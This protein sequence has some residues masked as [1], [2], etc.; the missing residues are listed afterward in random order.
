MGKVGDAGHVH[1]GDENFEI[2]WKDE[3]EGVVA[4]RQPLQASMQPASRAGAEAP[5]AAMLRSSRA[6][7]SDRASDRVHV[8][9][10]GQGKDGGK[11]GGKEGGQGGKGWTHGTHPLMLPDDELEQGERD[12]LASDSSSSLFEAPGEGQRGPEG[13]ARHDGDGSDH[14]DLVAGSLPCP[15]VPAL[16]VCLL[17]LPYVSALCIC[18]ICRPNF[19]VGNCLVCV[20]H[21]PCVSRHHVSRIT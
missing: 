19:A 16:C 14:S 7:A 3:K 20:L 13:A 17:C 8:H 11:E 2:I 9:R 18:L 12:A 4:G 10:E 5:T 6:A 21:V 15:F 1:G